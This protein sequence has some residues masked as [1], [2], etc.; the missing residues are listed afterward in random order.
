MEGSAEVPTDKRSRSDALSGRSKEVVYNSVK[1]EVLSA[2]AVCIVLRSVFQNGIPKSRRAPEL[3]D[4]F[5]PYSQGSPKVFLKLTH[6]ASRRPS[7][8]TL[9]QRD[10]CT[11]THTQL[12]FRK[13]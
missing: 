7:T 4:Q 3:T 12:P 1:T 9:H 13:Y 10:V 11:L 5:T 6:M 8:V 2:A